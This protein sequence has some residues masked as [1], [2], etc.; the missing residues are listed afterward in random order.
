MLFLLCRLCGERAEACPC[1]VD[2]QPED[3]QVAQIN[4]C[5]SYLQCQ[6]AALSRTAYCAATL[7][8]G[9]Q[10][11]SRNAAVQTMPAKPRH[12]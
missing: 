1:R 7:T 2:H 6:A 8:L 5:V 4:R 12:R 3:D 9:G 11:L 10:S